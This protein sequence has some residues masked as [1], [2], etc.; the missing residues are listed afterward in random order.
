MHQTLTALGSRIHHR[1]ILA[2]ARGAER[3][4]GDRRPSEWTQ[5]VP[6]TEEIEALCWCGR[7]TQKVQQHQIRRGW[8]A[9]CG[10]WRCNLI[11]RL[12]A[13]GLRE[14]AEPLVLTEYADSGMALRSEQDEFNVLR[15]TAALR[16]GE[17]LARFAKYRRT[18]AAL[19]D[20]KE[21]RLESTQPDSGDTNEEQ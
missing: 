8:T 17:R 21:P 19:A 7:S 10:T 2:Q 11:S 13:A 20:A 14:Y 3:P 16:F 5:I 1:Q 4:W 18:M 6:A 12:E 15:A 9:S